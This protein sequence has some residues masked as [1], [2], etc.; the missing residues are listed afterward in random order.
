MET[1]PIGKETKETL[2]RSPSFQRFSRFNRDASA[3]IAVA[4]VVLWAAAQH[5]SQQ[6]GSAISCWSCGC[7]SGEEVYY[8]GMIWQ[9]ALASIFPRAGLKLLGTDMCDE[10]IEIARKGEYPWYSLKGLPL[11]WHEEYF[12]APNFPVGRMKGRP[13][14][15]ERL[16]AAKAFAEQD[17]GPLYKIKGSVKSGV[18]FMKQDVTEE[19]PEGPFD[20]ILSRY[21]VCLYLQSAQLFTVLADMVQRLRP[22]GFLV[23]GAKDHLP[24]GFCEKFGLTAVDYR[25]EEVNSI[26]VLRC[27]FQKAPCSTPPS[28]GRTQFYAQFMRQTGGEPYWVAERKQLERQRLAVRMNQKSRDLMQMALDEGRRQAES[29]FTR[30]SNKTRAEWMQAREVFQESKKLS[31]G[32]SI[33]KEER[34]TRLKSFLKRLEQDL[35]ARGR[36]S[37]AVQLQ[38]FLP[39]GFKKRKEE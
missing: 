8:L 1:V 25:G 31:T 26:E 28:P 29:L 12:E 5:A 21:A 39:S 22:G 33:P 4:D 10:K 17:P 9:R 32:S 19:M 38:Q 6:G 16:E 35:A 2:A 37:I 3:W 18:S 13:K 27:I 15:A 23:I 36:K 30:G 34:A 24:N 20:I 14:A 7:S 11:D